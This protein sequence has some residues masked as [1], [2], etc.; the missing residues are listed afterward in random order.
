MRSLTS[1]D[2]ME[3][4]PYVNMYSCKIDVQFEI[5]AQITLDSITTRKSHSQES[6]MTSFD[7][8]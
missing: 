2:Q 6:S 3:P 5:G 7:P 4:C 1:D 8:G